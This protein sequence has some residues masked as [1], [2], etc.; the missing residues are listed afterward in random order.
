MGPQPKAS[1]LVVD[2]N[3]NLARTTAMILNRKGYAV[4]TAGDGGEALEKAGHQAF[5]IILMDI[6][7][8]VMNGVETYKQ[9]KS[10]RPDAAVIMMTA[11]AVEDLI[12]EALAE[13]AYGVLHKPLDIE[14]V[15]VLIN[16]ARQA[17][18][19]ALILVVDD[20]PSMG[21]TLK[22]ILD[23]R[24][25]QVAVA[26]SGEEAISVARQ[27]A[28]DILLIDIKLPVIN[29]LETYLGIKDINPEA[30][31]IFMTAY[32]QEVSDLVKEALRNNAYTCLYKPLDI[33][34]LLNLI[35][36][37]WNQKQCTRDAGSAA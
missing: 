25:Y 6:K 8:P 4:T 19:G 24:G 26:H 20:D 15:M 18:Q 37:I 12:Q 2:D 5:D 35:S 34:E 1:I 28:H 33:E 7:M 17:R 14:R 36:E 29:G 10:I 27:T 23:R 9:I 30:V 3:A 16:E 21:T 11:Y 32:R 22:N 13:G 31:A